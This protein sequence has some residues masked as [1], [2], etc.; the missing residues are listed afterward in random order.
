V[1]IRRPRLWLFVVAATLYLLVASG[2]SADVGAGISASPVVLSKPARPGS[3]HTVGGVRI[4][5]TGTDPAIM[6]LSLQP[7]DD[8]LT[9]ESAW[10]RFEPGSVRLDPKAATE[11]RISLAI[12]DDARDGEYHAYILVR[13]A[14]EAV[15]GATA[16]GAA[17]ATDLRFT[18][19]SGGVP[20]P[21]NGVFIALG[22][23]LLLALV[24][25]LYRQSGI[26]ISLRRRPSGA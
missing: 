5:N 15:A 14:P 20:L 22:I 25:I 9:V 23:L 18:V 10:V 2:A 13:S 3:Q 4:S 11:V 21:P 1:S 8:G 16:V 6:E 12:P 7:A 26:E 19:R 24:A 17:A